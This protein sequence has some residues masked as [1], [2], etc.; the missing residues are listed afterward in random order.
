[1]RKLTPRLSGVGACSPSGARMRSSARRRTSCGRRCAARR[2]APASLHPAG[3]PQLPACASP[4]SRA[5]VCLRLVSQLNG[6]LGLSE[7]LAGGSKGPLNAAQMQVLQII[8]AS[9]L[10]LLNITNDLLDAATM[11]ERQLILKW[12]NVKVVDIVSEVIMARATF[13]VGFSV[14]CLLIDDENTGG[15]MLACVVAIGAAADRGGVRVCDSGRQVQ[16]VMARAGVAIL[17]AMPLRFP[18][19]EGDSGRLTQA[20]ILLPSSPCA[21][22][23]IIKQ[24]GSIPGTPSADSE[25]A[26]ALLPRR[27]PPQVLHNLV[28]NACK[29]TLKA[30]CSCNPR[31]STLS[32]RAFH[33]AGSNVRLSLPPPSGLRDRRRRVQPGDGHGDHLRRGHGHRDEGGGARAHLEPLRAGAS[34]AVASRFIYSSPLTPVASTGQQTTKRRSIQFSDLRARASPLRRSPSCPPARPQADSSTSEKFGGTGLG[35]SLVKEL[36]E[37]H[38]GS[39]RVE[40]EPGSGTKFLITLRRRRAKARRAGEGGLRERGCQGAV[41][42]VPSELV[43]HVWA[44][45]LRAFPLCVRPPRT[46]ATGPRRRAWLAAARSAPTALK[47]VPAGASTGAPASEACRAP[48][49]AS[50]RPWCVARFAR[51]MGSSSDLLCSVSG[52]RS[53]IDRHPGCLPL[54]SG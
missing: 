31:R 43:A 20:R 10:R 17:N 53:L 18:V 48:T 22:P 42:L 36:V 1:M 51:E 5:P 4:A 39:I 28:S 47:R 14:G 33:T 29:F 44:L 27:T 54:S 50:I 6:I 49:V 45:C 2:I 30:R 26:P 8:R 46:G 16:S 41:V 11:K 3:A 52:E 35:L 19:I 34:G 38:G 25:P 7:V 37:A 23:A 24:I 12:D 15:C 9:G 32:A 40:S 13:P 21:R